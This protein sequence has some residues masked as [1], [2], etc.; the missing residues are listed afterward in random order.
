MYCNLLMR[1]RK[2]RAL[3]TEAGL[4][5]MQDPVLPGVHDYGY[6]KC[7]VLAQFFYN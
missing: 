5:S 1:I 2:I 7:V 4:D 3:N 6:Q